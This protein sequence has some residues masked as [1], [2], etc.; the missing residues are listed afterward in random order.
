V[1][2]GV[3]DRLAEGQLDLIAR[4]GAEAEL[5]GRPFGEVPGLFEAGQVGVDR[6]LAGFEANKG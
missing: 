5:G 3:G 1:L 6:V 2:D 4:V